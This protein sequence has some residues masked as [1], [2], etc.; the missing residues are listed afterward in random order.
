MNKNNY[1]PSQDPLLKL[2]QEMVLRNFSQKTI[3]TYLQYITKVLVFANKNPRN[4]TGDDVR[5]YLEKLANDGKSSST[6]NIAYN[7]FKFYF[8]KI[9]HRRFFV[10]IPRSKQSKYL[11]VVLSKEEI[12]K[13]IE[14]VDN[15]KHKFVIQLMYSTGLRVSEVVNIKMLNIDLDRKLLLVKAGKGNKDRYTI[16]A[17]SLVNIL[18]QQQKVKD[19]NDY[20]FTSRNNKTHW[21]VMSVQ[22]VIK[23]VARKANIVKNVSAHTLRHSFATHLLEGGNDIRYI[24]KLLGHKRLETTQIY[25]KVAN[26]SLEKI[27]NPLDSLNI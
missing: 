12:V 9:L 19:S 11:P 21:H 16:L 22:K 14:V 15:P 10:N 2:R 26:N 17:N 5:K 25:T 8:E 24:Q 20:L 18:K 13:M 27:V 1:Y 3:K 4:I 23:Q 7:A 6:V